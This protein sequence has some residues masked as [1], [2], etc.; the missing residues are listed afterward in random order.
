MALASS[1]YRHFTSPR[2]SLAC[3]GLIHPSRRHS[4]HPSRPRRKRDDWGVGNPVAFASSPYCRFTSARLA[5]APSGSKQVGMPPPAVILGTPVVHA[6][7]GTTGVS[8]IQRLLQVAPTVISPQRV[9]LQPP[10]GLKKVEMPPPAVILGTPVVHAEGGTTGVS[11]I[12]WLLQVAPTVVSPQRVLLPPPSGLK[13]V[14]TGVSGIQWLLQ[15]APTV[16]SP[17]RVL[18]PPRH[19]QSR[20]ECPLS[21]SFSAPQSSTPKAGRLGCRESSGSCK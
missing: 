14:G 15:V 12:Q 6:K 17:Q 20:W 2:L 10:S 13:K 18:L 1:T 16:V 4:L 21:P 8:G 3:P 5:P 7:G 19:D 11:R 9:L